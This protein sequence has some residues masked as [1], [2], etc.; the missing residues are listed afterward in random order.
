MNNVLSAHIRVQEDKAVTHALKDKHVEVLLTSPMTRTLYMLLTGFVESVI[1]IIVSL[2]MDVFQEYM[3]RFL[4]VIV[5]L[6][7]LM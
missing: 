5:P 3:P 2:I 7:S 1:F 6:I 4:I